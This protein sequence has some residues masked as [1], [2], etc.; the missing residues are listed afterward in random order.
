VVAGDEYKK[1]EP[2]VHI[3]LTASIL[4]RSL[5]YLPSKN[6]A[7]RLLVLDILKNG[8]LVLKD[9]EDELLPIV[10]Q[11][12]S[13]LVDRFKDTEEAVVV[14]YSF[15]LLVVLAQLSKEFI[16]S[17]TAKYFVRTKS[18]FFFSLKKTFRDVL[19]NLLRIMEKLS[20]ESYLKDNGSA[21]RYSQN[22]KL[23]L[24]VLEDLWRVMTDLDMLQKD[25]E[26]ATETVFKYVSDKQPI[27]LQVKCR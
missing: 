6:Q 12:W 5:H 2:P 27:P 13:P 21:Y 4:G 3:K 8:L 14:N 23:Q 1:P 15:Q 22:Y 7:R 20:R 26:N 19:P 9:W 10:H 11:I 25:F 24:S 18:C 16:R 17:R